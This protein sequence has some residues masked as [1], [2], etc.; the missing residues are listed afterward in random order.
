MGVSG[1]EVD[2]FEFHNLYT[3]SLNMLDLL[4][5]TRVHFQFR[6]LLDMF[7]RFLDLKNLLHQAISS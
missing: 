1:D 5:L 2:P 4:R 7:A 3:G 6:L